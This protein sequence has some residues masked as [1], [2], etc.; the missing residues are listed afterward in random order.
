MG[1]CSTGSRYHAL[2]FQNCGKHW[3]LLC[4]KYLKPVKAKITGQISSVAHFPSATFFLL[5]SILVLVI[6]DSFYAHE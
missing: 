3:P 1:Q 2:G 6:L 4:R 5:L